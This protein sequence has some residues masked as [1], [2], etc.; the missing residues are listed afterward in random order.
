M[1]RIADA[2]T[3]FLTMKR[4]IALSL[5]TSTPDASQRTR[6]TYVGACQAQAES[7]RPALYVPYIL[8]PA[9]RII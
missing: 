4:L 3:I 1:S 2:S 9:D 5:A 7:I 6:L 8:K